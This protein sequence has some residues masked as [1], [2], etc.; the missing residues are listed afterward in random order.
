M[1]HALPPNACWLDLLTQKNEA[2]RAIYSL[3]LK[4]PKVIFDLLTSETQTLT[5][6]DSAERKD[7]QPGFP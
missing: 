3:T 1:T 6:Y 4:C 2:K 5:L 7:V